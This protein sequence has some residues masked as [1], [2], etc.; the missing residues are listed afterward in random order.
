ML[1]IEFIKYNNSNQYLLQIMY[2]KILNLSI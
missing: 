1:T 2:K